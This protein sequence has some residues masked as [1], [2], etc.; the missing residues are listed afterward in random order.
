[1]WLAR[2][3]FAIIKIAIWLVQHLS[4]SFSYAFK[5]DVRHQMLHLNFQSNHKNAHCMQYSVAMINK[6]HELVLIVIIPHTCTRGKVIDCVVIVVVVFVVIIV[7]T[8]IT[9]SGDLGI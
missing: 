5:P 6:G 9:K 4:Q 3:Q 2:W 7:D 1:M 8:K